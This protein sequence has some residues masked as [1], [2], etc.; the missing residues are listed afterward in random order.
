MSWT[1]TGY[2][3]ILFSACQTEDFLKFSREYIYKIYDMNKQKFRLD[4]ANYSILS[5][6]FIFFHNI[7]TFFACKNKW[8]N[9]FLYKKE[10]TFPHF[11]FPHCGYYTNT[12]E[13]VFKSSLLKR[14]IFWHQKRK[15][16]ILN[17]FLQMWKFST[18]FFHK[19][20]RKRFH[21]FPLW[22]REYA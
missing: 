3:S 18:L 13:N 8:R 12:N 21:F 2:C 11:L 1:K 19:K 5:Y 7:F 4:Y 6:F 20:E 16:M 10:K 15:K 14:E 22:K 9:F 17:F